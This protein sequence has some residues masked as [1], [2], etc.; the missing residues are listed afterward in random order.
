MCCLR[1]KLIGMDPN[2]YIEVFRL[3]NSRHD[4]PRTTQMILAKDLSLVKD[5]L[6]SVRLMTIQSI[7]RAWIDIPSIGGIALHLRM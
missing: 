1:S 7:D 5:C 3:E 6:G 4:S 2:S